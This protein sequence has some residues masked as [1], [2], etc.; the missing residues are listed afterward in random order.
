MELL[1]VFAIVALILFSFTKFK[2]IAG[3]IPW[4]CLIILVLSFGCGELV[5]HWND[6]PNL[7]HGAGKVFLR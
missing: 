3:L 6:V 5:R 2:E 7:L 1:F 4:A